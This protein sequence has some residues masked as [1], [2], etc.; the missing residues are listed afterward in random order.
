RTAHQN[1]YLNVSAGAGEVK[2]DDITAVVKQ[3]FGKSY[4]KRYDENS[5]HIEASFLVD[6]P[7]PGSLGQ[8]REQIGKLGTV[9][10]SFVESKSF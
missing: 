7:R 2:L 4:L 5:D 9:N 3:V 8:F 6:S 10:I 1:L